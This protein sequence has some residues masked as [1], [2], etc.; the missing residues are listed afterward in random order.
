MA[1]TTAAPPPAAP[2]S[3]AENAIPL[4]DLSVGDLEP[5]NEQTDHELGSNQREPDQ[6]HDGSQSDA[7]PLRGAMVTAMRT[8][9]LVQTFPRSWLT[10]SEKSRQRGSY[11]L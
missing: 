8:S 10:L 9:Q 2:S 7:P 4:N 11:V 1:T 3:A 5:H 6:E